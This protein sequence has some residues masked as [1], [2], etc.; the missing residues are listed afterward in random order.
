VVINCTTTYH[1]SNAMLVWSKKRSASS[2]PFNPNRAEEDA[3]CFA[4]DGNGAIGGL[5][6]S[7][8]EGRVTTDE[9]LPREYGVRNPKVIWNRHAVMHRKGASPIV[10]SCEVPVYMSAVCVEDDFPLSYNARFL[11]I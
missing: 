2:K 9:A 5:I 10:R 4:A 11:A 1:A 7:F 8:A 3:K 6:L